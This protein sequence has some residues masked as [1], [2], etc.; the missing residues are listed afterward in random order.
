MK[1]ALVIILYDHPWK[2]TT[3]YSQQS[4]NVLCRDN[5]VICYMQKEARSLKEIVTMGCSFRLWRKYKKNIFLYTPFYIIPFRRF[6]RIERYNSWLNILVLKIIIIALSLHHTF[7]KKILWL[8]YPE[9]VFMLRFFG[10]S[11]ISI[12]DCVDYHIGSSPYKDRRDKIIRWERELI[13]TCRLF[14]V[15][16]HVLYNMHKKKRKDIVLVQQGFR[17][18]EFQKPMPSINIQFPSNRPI[19]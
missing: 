1:D 13:S 18:H 4:A 19:I 14:F 10:S 3:D 12:Y 6:P 2:H 17:I 15:N 7:S 16:S 8:F 11:Y 5:I 9:Y